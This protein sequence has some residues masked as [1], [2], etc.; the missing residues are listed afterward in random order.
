[1]SATRDKSQKIAFVYSNLY[2]LYKKG[3]EAAKAAPVSSRPGSGAV[4]KVGDLKEPVFAAVAPKIGEFVPVS[5]LNARSARE[6]SR[7]PTA[8]AIIEEVMPKAPAPVPLTAPLV[9]TSV[10]TPVAT[11]PS[12]AIR[13]LKDNLKNLNELHSKLRFMLQELEDLVK[14]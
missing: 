9:R 11:A 8:D 2:T 6:I 12:E 10:P 14:N 13:Q 3:K 7:Q 4:I 5:L 1:M